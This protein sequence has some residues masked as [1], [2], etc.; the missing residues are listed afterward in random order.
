MAAYN[1][2]ER[3]HVQVPLTLGDYYKANPKIA[4]LMDGAIMIIK[5]FNNHAYALGVFNEEQRAMS[6]GRLDVLALILPVITRWTSH[7][8]A[9]ARVLAVN[10]AMK[11]TVTK[12]EDELIE[13]AGNKAKLKAKAR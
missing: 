2:I 8:C 5:W 12:H 13:S 7:F 10:K 9:L 1:C 4:Q 3:A 11:I 6:D